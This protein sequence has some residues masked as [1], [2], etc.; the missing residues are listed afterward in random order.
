MGLIKEYN[1]ES[2]IGNSFIF[3]NK[4]SY[5]AI[6]YKIRG[7]SMERKRSAESTIAGY[8]YQFDKTIIELLSQVNEET[9]ICVEGIEDIDIQ[10]LEKL[11]DMSIQVKYYAKTLYKASEIK[12]P[13]QQMF[14][15]YKQVIKN[16]YKRRNYY[17]YAHFK[18]GTEKLKVNENKT[19]IDQT[20]KNVL[21]FF[22]EDLLTTKNNQGI[23]T[24]QLYIDS[25]VTITDEDLYDFIKLLVID[26]DAMNIHEQYNQVLDLLQKRIEN[27]KDIEDAENYYYNNALKVI[28]NKAIQTCPEGE[29]FEQEYQGL[30]GQLTQIDQGIKY[31]EKRIQ[32]QK[33]KKEKYEDDIISLQQEQ[34]EIMQKLIEEDYLKKAQE[35][36]IEKRKI[37]QKTFLEIIDKKIILFNKWY[38]WHRGKN[39][40]YEYIIEKLKNTKGLSNTK[41]R[42]LYIDEKYFSTRESDISFSDLVT[43]IIQDSY[44]LHE[45]L[46]KHKVWTIILDAKPDDITRIKSQLVKKSIKFND[47]NESWGFFDVN[48]FNQDPIF[49]TDKNSVIIQADYQIKIISAD[50]FK[51][52]INEFNNIDV[53]I[54]FGNNNQHDIIFESHNASIYIIE[55]TKDFKGLSDISKIFDSKNKTNQFFRILSVSPDSIQVEVT[56]PDK[57]KNSNE[58][59]TLGSYVKISDEFNESVIGILKNYKIK[60]LNEYIDGINMKK[61]NPSFILDIHPI[62]YIQKNEFYRGSNNITIPPNLVEIVDQELLKNIFQQDIK[63]KEFCFSSLPQVLSIN[64]KAI[65]VVLDGDNFFNKHL[66]VIGSTGS[67][68]SCTVAKILHEGIKPFTAEQ[69]EG[70]LNNSH[71]IIFDIHGEYQHSFKDKCRVL[72]VED[73]KLPYWLMNSEELEDFFLDVEGSDHNQ[74]N[75]FKRAVVLNKKFHN[76]DTD[77]NFRDEITYDT[78]VYFNIKEVLQYIKNFNISKEANGKVVFRL[79]DQ[80]IEDNKENQE[81][82]VLFQALEEVERAT[83]ITKSSFNGNFTGFINRLETKLN[84]DRLKFLLNKGLEYKCK[85]SDIIKQLIGYKYF[86]GTADIEKKNIII[87]DLSGMPFEVINHIVSLISRLIFNFAFHRKKIKRDEDVRIPFLLVYEEAHNYIPRSTEAK[88]KSVKESVE[89]VAKEGRKYGVSAMIVSQRPSEISETIFSQCNSFVVMRVTN[90][91]DQAYIKKLLPDDVSSLTDSLSSFK[92]REALVIGESIPMPA[93]VEIH[94]LDSDKLPKSNDVQ[95]MQKW[96]KD[97]DSF[98]EFSKIIESLEGK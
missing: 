14:S 4:T 26:L 46:S 41:A 9:T 39:N 56:D 5:K 27:C 17:L 34:R 51:K 7:E 3:C 62:G 94:K 87:V 58:K 92:Q 21:D 84:D 8:L 53:F 78:P 30:R 13:I 75:I 50:N 85:L 98:D 93:V 55:D 40:Y 82:G 63:E 37:N 91:N 38:A 25:E 6:N 83:G 89:R 49:Y 44:A 29:R 80:Q 60:D 19:L 79:N 1:I 69:K 35:K 48:T 96:R 47:G 77:N 22:K 28:F 81:S 70:L 31:R 32:E 68:K 43:N 65:S 66:A 54:C 64:S 57:F 18:E 24:K 33:G 95:F 71:I 16:N 97:W 73:M 86:D 52:N 74:R 72:T 36:H 67:G 42:Y 59:F 45:A 15:H 2:F 76:K 12:E 90:P 11:N 20:D 88:Y 61:K 23:V 10:D